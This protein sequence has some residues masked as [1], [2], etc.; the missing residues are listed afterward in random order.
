MATVVRENVLNHVITHFSTSVSGEIFFICN[1]SDCL[2]ARFL[3]K[4]S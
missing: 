3:L 4:K 1:V 2:R